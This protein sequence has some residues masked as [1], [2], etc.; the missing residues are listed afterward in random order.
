MN[1]IWGFMVVAALVCGAVSGKLDEV[2]KASIDNAEVAV[3]LA[4]GL[5][6]MM[7][8]WI[9]LMKVL[10]E[11]GFLA[12][13]ARWLRPLM[14][15]LFPSVPP[16]HPAMSM[17]ILNTSANILGLSNAATPFG[18][19]AMAE[20]DKLNDHRGEASD[21]M[22]LF[23]AINT[24]GVCVFPT[25]MIALR[26][27]MGSTAPGSIIFPTLLASVIGTIVAVAAALALQRLPMFRFKTPA[28]A[29]ARADV[30]SGTAQGSERGEVR[31]RP[32]ALVLSLAVACVLAYALFQ[33][34]ADV[35]WGEAVKTVFA[36]WSLV[37]LIGAITLAGLVR[38]VKIYDV[39]VEGGKEGFDIALRIIPFLVAML[40]GVGMLR[41]AGVIDMIVAVL[42]P[43][44]SL[45]GMPPEI[46][47]MAFLRSLTGGGSMGVATEIMKTHGPDSLAGIIASS[48]YGSSETTFYVI[49]VYFGAVQVKNGRHTLLVCLLADAAAVLASV[50]LCRWMFF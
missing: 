1:G 5:V 37:L 6:G 20:L 11:A 50:W 44:T 12:V 41:A 15:R 30:G 23:L 38:G 43:V 47:P 46:L 18:L 27:T 34:A 8:L 42:R 33:K 49:A 25:T 39:V 17:M 7:S 32:W 48:I 13:L 3:K 2:S 29:L 35:G 22:A 36:D 28:V 10:D 4:I 40:V 9:G 31:N 26:A 45:I 14:R 21:A 19:K 16:E 24:A